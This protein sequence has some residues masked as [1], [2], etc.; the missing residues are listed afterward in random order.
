MNGDMKQ[1]QCERKEGAITLLNLQMERASSILRFQNFPEQKGEDTVKV[2]TTF[3]ATPMEMQPEE[4][5]KNIAI[6]RAFMLARFNIFPSAT[7]A[8]HFLNIPRE[9]NSVP[10]V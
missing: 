6:A 5:H 3:L 8:G 9:K 1:I 10:F 2:A 7:Y 4:D